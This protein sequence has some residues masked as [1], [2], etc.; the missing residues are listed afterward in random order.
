MQTGPL[1]GSNPGYFKR[2][3]GDVASIALEFL[4]DV[5]GLA[6]ATASADDDDDIGGGNDNVEG[7][8][9]DYNEIDS[10]NSNDYSCASSST[11]DNE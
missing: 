9:N 7:E 2:C 4:T 6:G 5:I 3:G 1:V 8:K 10:P 11:D